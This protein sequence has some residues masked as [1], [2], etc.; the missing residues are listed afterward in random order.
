[1]L[2]A[3]GRAPALPPFPVRVLRLRFPPDRRV[4][5]GAAGT[6]GLATLIARLP[7]TDALGVQAALT[8]LAHDATS[9][10]DTRTREQRRADLLTTSLTGAPATYGAPADTEP[11]TTGPTGPTSPA[12]PASG[13]AVTVRW[14]DGLPPGSGHAH[15]PVMEH[16]VQARD[17][18]CPAP[19]CTRAPRRVTATTSCPTHTAPPQPR[20]RAA[21]ADATTG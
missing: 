10:T 12:G 4:W 13:D 8:A 18:V 20:T 16:L 7:D 14:L 3:W 6:D 11:T 19:G 1:M 9:P 2:V 15:P 21:C 5:V 17:T